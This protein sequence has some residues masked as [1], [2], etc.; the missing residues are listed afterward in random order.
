M[1]NTL[2]RAFVGNSK[3]VIEVLKACKEMGVVTVGLTGECNGRMA[4][5]CDYCIKALSTVT[6]RIY[7]AHIL[8]GH[9]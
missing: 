1:E 5:L 6:P 9:I 3:N 8:I 2:I 4:D 7:E